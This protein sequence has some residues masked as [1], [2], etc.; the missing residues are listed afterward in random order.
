MP[1]MPIGGPPEFTWHV[2]F[3]TWASNPVWDLLIAVALAAYVLGL[4]VARRRRTGGLPWYR[5]L[6]FVLAVLTL[7]VSVNTAIETYSEVLFWVHMI[8]HLLLIMVVPALLVVASPLTLLLQVTRGAH[9]ERVR[10]A[11]TSGPVSLLTHPLAGI[12]IYAVVIVATH[13]TSFMQHMMLHPWLHQ[14]ESVLYVGAGYVFLLPLIGSEPIR[15]RLPFPLRLLMLFMA[16]APETVV[17]IVLLQANHVLF[18]AYADM[19]RSWGPSPLADLNRGGGIMWAFG[20]GLMMTLIVGVVLVYVT[21]AAANS[22]AG[23]WLE[24]VR[25]STLS[26]HLDAAGEH[27][28]LTGSDLDS[29]DAALTAYNAMLAR[30]NQRSGPHGSSAEGNA[31]GNGSQRDS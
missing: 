2:V 12:S 5:V 1:D 18:P 16:M 24:D 4:V 10:R 19:N 27:T 29:D 9:Q 8:Q 26:E 28:D 22:T 30:L 6:S 15:W 20:D 7:V 11:L 31:A 23:S 21:H 17:G 14:F 25:R 13:L 3:T